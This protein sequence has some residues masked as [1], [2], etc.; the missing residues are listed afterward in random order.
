M[1]TVADMAGACVDRLSAR[2]LRMTTL[3]DVVLPPWFALRVREKFRETTEE[4][5]KPFVADLFS[6]TTQALRQWSDRRK[7]IEVPVF[8]G[9]LFAR[10]V[11][12]D[13]AQILRVP[14]VIDLVRVG[15]RPAEVDPIE[16]VS[17]R[18]ALAVALPVT[19]LPHL[20]T[21]Q[22]VR[23]AGGA[24]TGVEGV[25]ARIKSEWKLVISVTMMNRSVAVELDRIDVVA[26]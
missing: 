26:S 13:T 4:H 8:P 6:P 24:M 22:A 20:V 25:L 15:S 7:V 3:P 10:F 9:Y 23:V 14:G 21:G 12:E 16:I 2:E 1:N 11:P 17:L 18:Q 19:A 5:L